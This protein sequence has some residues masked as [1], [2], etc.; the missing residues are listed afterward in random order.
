MKYSRL[1]DE[2]ARETA[3][4]QDMDGVLRYVS[5]CVIGLLED[6]EEDD[7][8]LTAAC[9]AYDRHWQEV[10]RNFPGEDG[11]KPHKF[12]FRQAL[13]QAFK[14]VGRQVKAEALFTRVLRWPNYHFTVRPWLAARETAEIVI[15]YGDKPVI[16]KVGLTPA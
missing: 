13:A 5:A 6:I 15:G 1:N 3:A 11:L 16:I 9:H 12:A 7:N 4:T 8:V 14:C 2:A 10:Q